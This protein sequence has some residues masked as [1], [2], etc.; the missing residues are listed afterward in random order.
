MLNLSGIKV[1]SSPHVGEPFTD[2]NGCRSPARAMRRAKRGF[3]QR[4]KTAY[5]ANGTFFHD[6]LNN[7]VYCHPDDYL[8]LVSKLKTREIEEKVF[9]NA[10][11]GG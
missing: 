6:M 1:Y 8:R 3:P 5:R 2:W 11:V 9:F 4:V 7:V 10:I